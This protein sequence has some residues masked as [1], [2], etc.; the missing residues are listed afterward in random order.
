MDA[1]KKGMSGSRYLH[2]TAPEEQRRLAR[3]NELLNEASLRELR[4]QGGEKILEVGSGLGQ[5]ARRMRKAAGKNGSV[6]GIERSEE[7]I[8]EALRRA[9]EEGEE[10]LANFRQ[11]DALALPLREEEWGS[12]DLAHARFLLEHVSD[13][14]AVVRGMIRAVRPGG[15]IVLADDDHDLLRLWP[16]LPEFRPVWAAY[17]RSFQEL[18]NDPY[19]GRRLVSLLHDGGAA[20]KRNTWIFFG[21]CSGGANFEDLIENAIGLIRGAQKVIVGA[22]FLDLASLQAG[23]SAFRAWGRRRDAG[24]WFAMPWAEGTRLP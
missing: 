6:L 13:P 3:L 1:E 11:G 12:F 15:R 7:Q 21:S 18:G 16:D 20:P 9:R 24:L 17:V 5:F 22:E 8:A 4:L 14:L 2:G 23:V 19:V 10:G